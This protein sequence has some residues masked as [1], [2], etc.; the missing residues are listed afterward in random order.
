[1]SAA[2]NGSNG[3]P[4][5]PAW[6]VEFVN[7]LLPPAAPPMPIR[8]PPRSPKLLLAAA[9]GPVAAEFFA[10]IVFWRLMLDPESPDQKTPP[11]VKA[12]LALIVTLS[13]FRVLEKPAPRSMPPPAPAALFAV[14]V[15][16][17]MD[18]A[19]AEPPLV[20]TSTPPPFPVALLLARGLLWRAHVVPATNT[21]LPWPP[22]V[23]PSISLVV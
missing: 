4:I 8:L 20:A 14:M 22:L 17:T 19:A 6:V 10:R 12:E 7:P 9:S 2:S 15:A 1:P 5:V 3:L 23:L 11:P 21:P 16:S 18:D 13:S